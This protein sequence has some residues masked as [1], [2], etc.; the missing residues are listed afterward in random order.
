MKKRTGNPRCFAERQLVNALRSCPTFLPP[1]FIRETRL[2]YCVIFASL[3]IGDSLAA[4]CRFARSFYNG[5]AAGFRFPSHRSYAIKNSM[6]LF[7]KRYHCWIFCEK[8]GHVL[9]ELRLSCELLLTSCFEMK[10]MH[11]KNVS[12]YNQLFVL[13]TY[14][15]KLCLLFC[16][17]IGL[18]LCP[19]AL[20]FTGNL[21]ND[22]L[23]HA[24]KKIYILRV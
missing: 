20:T 3:L 22:A 1:A 9:T 19:L 17:K 15:S 11:T 16:E 13:Q 8:V 10:K 24:A 21:I 7:K 23:F 5:Q 2:F 6:H 14:R 12:S 18:L 4:F